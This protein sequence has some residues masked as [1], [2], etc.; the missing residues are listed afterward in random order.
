ME[1]LLT[2]DDVAE[3]IGVSSRTV[4]Q[5]GA[6]TNTLTRVKL[7]GAVRFRAE[8]VDRWILT[9][10]ERPLVLLTPRKRKSKYR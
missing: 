7:G 8:D 5:R 1:K 10:V 2:I 4:R 3:L 6:G 9:R